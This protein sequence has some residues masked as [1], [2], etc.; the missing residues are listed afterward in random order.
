[1]EKE[2]KRMTEKVK[3]KRRQEEEKRKR[4]QITLKKQKQER[5]Q[6]KEK[7]RKKS[8]WDEEEK[9]VDTDE[10]RSEDS[11]IEADLKDGKEYQE[12]QSQ[13]SQLHPVKGLGT[14]RFPFLLDVARDVSILFFYEDKLSSCLILQPAVSITLFDSPATVCIKLLLFRVFEYI[15]ISRT[16]KLVSA[17]KYF[18]LIK[19]QNPYLIS[20]T[21]LKPL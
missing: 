10:D 15:T 21:L 16:H 18:L 4:L 20:F 11:S 17:S 6:R 7:G 5:A 13:A 8:V 19:M 3:E 14:K 12:K 2:Q 1:M 9:D